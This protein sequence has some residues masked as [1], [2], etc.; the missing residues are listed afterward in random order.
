MNELIQDAKSEMLNS[1]NYQP[2]YQMIDI[3]KLLE[4]NEEEREVILSLMT[5]KGY[6]FLSEIKVM[7]MTKGIIINVE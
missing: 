1:S 7:L 6:D 4:M 5:K 2:N 3:D